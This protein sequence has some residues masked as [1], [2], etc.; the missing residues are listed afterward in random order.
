MTAFQGKDF[1]G[2]WE[3]TP[4]SE[5]H[6]R[7]I[8]PDVQLI[9]EIEAELGYRFPDA[10][11]DLMRR[12]NGGLLNHQFFPFEGEEEAGI[13]VTGIMGIGRT[14]MYSLCGVFG[15]R[16]WIREWGYPPIGIVIGQTPSA[17]HQLIFMDY[18]ECGS[19]GEPSVVLVDQE[20]NYKITE[21]APDFESFIR[22][23]RKKQ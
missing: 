8:R 23:L 21:L 13:F 4:Y 22:G 3:T 18:R 5:S 10:Y 2:F 9:T 20:A 15:S 12:Q 19:T 7:E 11:V 16:Y 1:T 6:Y 14:K 17:G